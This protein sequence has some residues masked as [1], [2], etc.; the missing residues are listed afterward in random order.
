MS[1]KVVCKGMVLNKIPG[2]LLC[3]SLSDF[4][5]GSS[6]I[7]SVIQEKFPKRAASN[8]AE[9]MLVSPLGDL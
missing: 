7:N 1:A 4:T 5:T 6:L 9:C 3:P 8:S 2:E